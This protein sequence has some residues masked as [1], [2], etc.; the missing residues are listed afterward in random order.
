MKASIFAV[1][2]SALFSFAAAWTAPVGANPQGNPISKPGLNEVVPAGTPYTITWAPT[3]A[4]TVTLLLLRGPSTNVVPLYALGEKI[5]NTG[6]F[7]WVPAS[8]LE[9]DVTHY[10][11][12]LIEDDTG[13]YQYTTQFGISN[14]GPVVVSSSSTSAAAPVPTTSSTSAVVVP[15]TSAVVVPTTSATPVISSTAIISSSTSAVVTPPVIIASESSA[16]AVTTS[17][18]TRIVT[19]TSCGT[20]VTNCP[21]ITHHS[22]A[23]AVTSAPAVIS[24]VPEVAAPPVVSWSNS[25][26][27]QNS[28]TSASVAST[29]FGASDV[30]TALPTLTDA[31][32]GER[33]RVGCAM[34]AVMVAAVALAM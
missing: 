22:S 17:Y 10:G 14:S 21:A 6:S 19:I 13:F 29:G 16:A 3:S 31:N 20:A 11:I 28:P 8:D 32:A 18:S 9:A 5:P 33:I 12:E 15:T 34:V 1:A 24:S 7:T 4:S 23:A 26:L 27:V 25:T 2:T 30:P